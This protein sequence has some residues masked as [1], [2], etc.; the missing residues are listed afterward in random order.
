ML[1]AYLYEECPIDSCPQNIVTF[2]DMFNEKYCDGVCAC[3]SK[4]LGQIS[5]ENLRSKL[6]FDIEIVI[7]LEDYNDGGDYGCGYYLASW[8][9]KRLFWLEDVDYEFIT[10]EARI[11]LT[12]SHIGKCSGL[13]DEDSTLIGLVAK[14]VE[15]L[16][17]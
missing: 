11:C 1:F 5:A 16:F 8:E 15:Q 10:L 4:L 17:W 2:V 6:P 9:E 14:N 13:R 7:M 12:E 3:A